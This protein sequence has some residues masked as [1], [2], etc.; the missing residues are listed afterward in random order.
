MGNYPCKK[1]HV[2]SALITCTNTVCCQ[3]EEVTKA[4][5][6]LM[7]SHVHEGGPSKEAL[8]DFVKTYFSG[9][10]EDLE[11]LTPSDW[12]SRYEYKCCINISCLQVLLMT[13]TLL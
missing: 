9:P 3:P 12:S 6:A 4:F 10:G 1:T 7:S 8:E 5:E 2:S 11:A 13:F